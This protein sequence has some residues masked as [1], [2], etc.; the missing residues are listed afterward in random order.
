[1]DEGERVDIGGDQFEDQG[2][3]WLNFSI[4][5]QDR[6]PELP[7]ILTLLPH[8]LQYGSKTSFWCNKNKSHSFITRITLM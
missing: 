6:H 1:M 4:T 5:H 2:K 7:L 8:P 3:G